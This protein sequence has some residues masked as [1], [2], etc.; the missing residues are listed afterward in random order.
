MQDAC[1]SEEANP[2]NSAAVKSIRS[3]IA[4]DMKSLPM[5]PM[6]NHKRSNG[7]NPRKSQ[8]P[9]FGI[10]I[11]SMGELCLDHPKLPFTGL[12]PAVGAHIGRLFHRSRLSFLLGKPKQPIASLRYR[13][14]GECR[15]RVIYLVQGDASRPLYEF[16]PESDFLYLQWQSVF[17]PMENSFHFPNSSWASGRNELYR[18]AVSKGSYD[19]LIFLD[20]DL[21]FDHA[22]QKDRVRK[23]V[24][25]LVRRGKWPAAL[26]LW[27]SFARCTK[28]PPKLSYFEYLLAENGSLIA[29]P[30][31]FDHPWN[32]DYVFSDTDAVTY[33][34]QALIALHHSV[35][36]ELLP[37]STEFDASNW[38]ICGELFFERA[39]KL[40][41]GRVHR[42]SNLHV[43]NMENRPYPRQTLGWILPVNQIGKAVREKLPARPQAAAEQAG[44]DDTTAIVVTSIASS[45]K[46]LRVIGAKHS[47]SAFQFVV[48]GDAKSP[49]YFHV[50]DCDYYP[51]VRQRELGFR[52][53]KDLPENHY[54]RKNLGYLAVLRD[55]HIRF[56]VETDDDNMPLA[57]FWT[58]RTT[59][60]DVDCLTGESW[61]NIYRLFTKQNVWPRGFPLEHVHAQ[62]A[63]V[64]EALNGSSG[65][66]PSSL[67]EHR[68]C[69]LQQGLA[70]LDPDVDAFFRLTQPLPV[71]FRE[72]R[73]VYLEPGLW[74]PVNSQN[75]TWS[76]DIAPLMYL[77][78]NC[79]MRETDIWRGLLAQRVLW[80]F[81]AGVMFHQATVVQ[82]RNTHN[83][84]QDFR[85][86]IRLY[87]EVGPVTEHLL[88]LA[89]RPEQSAM[90]ENLR[91]CYEELVRLGIFPDAELAL[92]DAWLED[93]F[94]VCG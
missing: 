29:T 55:P 47:H 22:A 70:Q 49:P 94:D 62:T 53:E 50:Q 36:A 32:E 16:P 31:L 68:T 40:Y 35:A 20:D 42:F 37:Y 87:T 25:R 71:W 38:W 44:M 77:P 27:Q 82:D 58:P 51:L 69:L 81:G 46:A 85:E 45:T 66:N 23:H 9:G 13:S 91:H 41:S 93:V 54:S 48:I 7:E 60:H 3:L 43:F 5:L 79:E 39:A 8:F 72:R 76:V 67:A 80:S 6:Q 84:T 21:S 64:D 63:I 17:K 56:I 30:R 14:S 83:L 90:G 11:K 33:A 57:G 2:R 89:L 88:G 12:P 19:Y 24:W 34:D 75:T 59:N 26:R 18:R 61:V 65:G 92:L 28:A 15:M 78:S 86:E 74:S 52:L 1:W 73:P 10:A 4:A